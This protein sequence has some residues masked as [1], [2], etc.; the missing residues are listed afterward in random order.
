MYTWSLIYCP[1]TLWGEGRREGGVRRRKRCLII[2]RCDE[3]LERW[4]WR[5][6]L[7]ESGNGSSATS[8]N[9]ML[10]EVNLILVECIYISINNK[11]SQ[12]WSVKIWSFCDHLESDY[13]SS[14][15]TKFL[16]L[17]HHS[18]LISRNYLLLVHRLNGPICR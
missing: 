10:K 7:G 6:K 8:F 12:E 3:L 2:L 18:W 5:W 1:V 15:A 16:V 17:L 9:E 14:F 4:K 11:F 13:S